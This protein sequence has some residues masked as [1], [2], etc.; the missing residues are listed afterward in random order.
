MSKFRLDNVIEV[1]EKLLDD[2]RVE[3]ENCLAEINNISNDINE[4]SDTINVNYN[5]ISV[6]T[7]SGSDFYVIKEYI[8]YLEDKNHKLIGQ[9]EDLK[10]I[11]DSLTSELFELLKEIKMLEIL[12][13]KAL[14][15]IKKSENRREQKIL[16]DLALRSNDRR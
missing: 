2:K 5:K 14:R 15:T 4:I 1:K 3:M 6:T 7:L 8:I 16:D 12:K 11:A 10:V 13:S 9:R